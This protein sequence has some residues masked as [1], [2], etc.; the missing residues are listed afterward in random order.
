MVV[1]GPRPTIAGVWEAN[2]WTA[3]RGS[4]KSW[5]HTTVLR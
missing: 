3:E 4:Y 5:S 1:A 2:I